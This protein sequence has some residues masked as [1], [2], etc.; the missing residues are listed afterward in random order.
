MCMATLPDD[1]PVVGGECDYV[2]I[3]GTCG[4]MEGDDSYYNF[5]PYDSSSSVPDWADPARVSVEDAPRDAVSFPCSCDF[6]VSGTCTPIMCMAILPEDVRNSGGECEYVES[7]GTC[8]ATDSDGPYYSFTPDDSSS[9]IPDWVDLERVYNME[10][11]PSDLESFPCSCDFI[12]WERARRS[13]AHQA[14]C[15]VT[16]LFLMWCML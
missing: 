9:S 11:A 7:E 12:V 4:A 1:P 15:D 14:R 2:E 16:S 13:C 5:T 8:S 10:D 6:I 3:A